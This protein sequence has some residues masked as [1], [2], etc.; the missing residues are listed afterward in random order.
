MKPAS[1]V[2]AHCSLWAALLLLV[3]ASVSG[4][5]AAPQNNGS[6]Q[7]A[8][9]LG[10]VTVLGSATC[11]SGATRGAACT[12]VSVSCPGVPDLNATLSQAFPWGRP[13][14]PSF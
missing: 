9:P 2:R 6:N 5:A 10:T 14:A 3:L 13:K 1:S 12:S 7:T 11:L 8:L 4:F